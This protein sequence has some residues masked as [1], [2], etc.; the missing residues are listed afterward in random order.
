MSG[1]SVDEVVAGLPATEAQDTGVTLN[2]G[3]DEG[4]VDSVDYEV[5]TVAEALARAE[6]DTA[7]WE[8]FW[9]KV[10][11]YQVGMKIKKFREGRT[12]KEQP[13]KRTLW[14]VSVKL[15]RKVPK[16]ILHSFEALYARM[17]GHEPQYLKLPKLPKLVDPHMLEVALFDHH[18]GK[19]AWQPET[20]SN[21]NL[22]IAERVYL[23]AIE[24]LLVRTSGYPVEKVLFPI[25][26]DFFHVDNSKNRTTNDTPQDLDSRYAKMIEIGTLAV[27]KAIDRLL[28]RAAVKV[29]WVPGNHD[30]TT[31][32]H[33]VRE[34]KAWY[35]QCERVEIDVSP[36]TRKYEIYN[37]SL[38]GFTHGDEEPHRDLP[39]IMASEEPALWAAA[40]DRHW[41]IGHYHKK[42]EMRHTAADS[43]GNCRVTILPSLSGTDA[44]HYRK[45]FVGSRRAAEA[46]LWS[47]K[48]GYTGQFSINARNS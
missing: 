18:F 34:L 6:V 46:W 44:W 32:Y 43:F 39:T 22:K 25:G 2:L 1:Q 9:S 30:R 36:K 31:S 10:N 48:H 24:D 29:L 26:Q 35:R 38:I 19:L 20:G 14:Q 8:P 11:S 7:I 3:E 12:V 28:E 27:V 5:R 33:L 41:H 17:E 40:E 42:K 13:I 15:R 45:G 21:Y 23:Q 16:N 37:K 4:R 47:K